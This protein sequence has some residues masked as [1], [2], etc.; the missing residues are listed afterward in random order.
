MVSTDIDQIV[1]VC[2]SAI[3]PNLRYEY[4]ETLTAI[5]NTM[6][7]KTAQ[8]LIDHICDQ[9]AQSGYP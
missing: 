1:E 8:E 5:R 2:N 6:G 7:E 4:K 9:Q 3:A